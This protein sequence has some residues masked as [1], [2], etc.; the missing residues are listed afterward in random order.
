MNTIFKYNVNV[1]Y[2]TKDLRGGHNNNNLSLLNVYLDEKGPSVK[3]QLPNIFKGH[4]IVAKA[5]PMIV[6]CDEWPLSFALWTKFYNSYGKYKPELNEYFHMYRCQL[7]L[8]CF[9]PQVH[10]VSLGNTLTIQTYLYAV[11]IDFTCIFM[12]D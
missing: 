7:V 12:Y 1:K 8:P 11:F 9:V 10:L 4:H 3:D 6:G 5:S 2:S